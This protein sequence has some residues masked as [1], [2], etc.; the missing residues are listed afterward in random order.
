MKV[1]IRGYYHRVDSVIEFI[2]LDNYALIYL[3]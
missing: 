1:A 2:R 3:R